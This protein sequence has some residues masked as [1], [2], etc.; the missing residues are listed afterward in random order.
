MV[1]LPGV[2][3]GSGRPHRTRDHPLL[4][5]PGPR[6]P[7]LPHLAFSVPAAGD[8]HCHCLGILAAPWVVLR[9]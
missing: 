9:T 3:V 2:W 1:S 8:L 6:Q 4:Y 5:V 7:A